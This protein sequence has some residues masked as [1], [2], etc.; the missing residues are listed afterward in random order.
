MKF[1]RV[2]FSPLLVQFS[3]DFGEPPKVNQFGVSHVLGFEAH[4][5]KVSGAIWLVLK[6]VS[7]CVF[8]AL[9]AGF[10]CL[11]R[12]SVMFGPTT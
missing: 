2:R 1:K 8:S 6:S 7:F 10:D 11:G 12:H 9:G 5:L 4:G 3:G